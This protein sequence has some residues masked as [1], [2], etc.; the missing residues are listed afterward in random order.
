MGN[1]TSVPRQSFDKG[2][3]PLI[4]GSFVI[5]IFW[6]TD[7]VYN[8]VSIAQWSL[9]GD[10]PAIAQL[11]LPTCMLGVVFLQQLESP[12]PGITALAYEAMAILAQEWG[13]TIRRRLCVSRRNNLFFCDLKEQWFLNKAVSAVW[14]GARSKMSW[15]CRTRLH[16]MTRCLQPAT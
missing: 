6:G 11:Q 2:P 4:E 14:R 1:Y 12:R 5:G 10:S 16:F 3:M 7:Q 9:T 15:P 8:W 13:S